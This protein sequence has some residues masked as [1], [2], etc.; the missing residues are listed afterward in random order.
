MPN[1]P[2]SYRLVTC[3]L[4]LAL[5]LGAFLPLQAAF[6][7]EEPPPAEIEN[8]E[9]GPVVITGEVNYTNPLFTLGVAAPMIIL[10]DQAGFVDRNKGFIFP[11]ESQTIGQITSDF[12]TPPFAYSLSLPIEPQGSLRD[13][14][15]DGD[16]DEGVMVF[17][18]AYWTNTW[19]DPFLE[20]RDMS[21]GGWSS[22]YASTRVSE[23]W[24]TQYEYIGGTILVYARD[25][26]QGFP[27]GFGPDNLLFTEDDPIVTL[28]QGYTLVNMDTDPFTFSREREAV[29]DLIEPE[30]T[31]LADYS[32]LGYAEAFDSL[33]EQLRTDYAFTEFK[34]IDWDALHAEFRP[35]FE[36]AEETGDVGAYFTALTEFSW[37]IPDGHINAGTPL[38]AAFQEA[39]SGGIGLALRDLDDG[40]VVV[41]YLVAGGPAEEAG[42]ELEA[43]VTEI[44]GMPVDEWVEQTVAWSAPF[45]TEHFER[46]QKLRYAVRAPLGSDFEITYQNPGDDEP[47]TVTL[48]T[49]SEIES[50][51]VTSF[52]GSTTGLELP[53]EYRPLEESGYMYSAIFS[54]AD[55]DLLSIQLWE[56]MIRALNEQGVP[57][58]VI[59]MRQNGG[60]NGFLA[61]QMAAYFFQEEHILGNTGYYDEATDEFQFDEDR[62]DRFYL[63]DEDLRYNGRVAV[64]VG[65]NCASACEFFTYAMTVDDR[66]AIVGFYPT[67]GL[68]GS[69]EDIAMPEGI[70]FRMTIGRAVDAEGNIH[71]EGQ[72]VA[73]T[74]R[75]PQA[76]ETLITQPGEDP[77]LDAAIA[78]LDDATTIEVEDGGEIALGDTVEGE[79]S[80][81][82]RVAYTLDVEGGDVI[83]ITLT[84]A[85]DEELD[86]VLRLY[87]EDELVFVQDDSDAGGPNAEILALEIPADLT[88]TI[89]AATAG[90]SLAGAFFLS[91]LESR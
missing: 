49:S 31:A 44:N 39:I 25:D 46:L 63:P 71:I 28:P 57:G 1:N 83:D 15:Q 37:Q 45:S 79:F 58:L 70:F 29:V 91:V 14:D 87:L 10:E 38:D 17:A 47:T 23:D 78:W 30:G 33:I 67:A 74:V 48:A 73:P 26:Q 42:I 72:G 80:D 4:L 34:E 65:P 54:F 50:F 27:S 77:V 56:R 59:D 19:G 11:P 62:V 68:G 82:E 84:G 60:G 24:E 16:E 5:L 22:A 51:S 6:A 75:V 35:R 85:D 86:T 76:I 13:V 12:Y 40:R 20:V 32:A 61:D 89:E 8:D 53:V 3:A 9:G 18:I 36:Q 55:N 66:A 7:Q 2:R 90:D 64:L 41:T 88:L 52:F 69:I 43:E 21:G 81:G